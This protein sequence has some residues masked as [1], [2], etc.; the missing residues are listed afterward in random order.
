[1]VNTERESDPCYLSNGLV[2][3]FIPVGVYRRGS[4]CFG[5]ADL[6]LEAGVIDHAVGLVELI[7]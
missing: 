4:V 5:L 2:K 6:C 1:M 7:Q 3:G